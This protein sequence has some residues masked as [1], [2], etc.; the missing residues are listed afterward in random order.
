MQERAHARVKKAL[1][2]Q[3]TAGAP[4]VVLPLSPNYHCWSVQTVKFLQ[5]RSER[6][7][8]VAH[9][10]GSRQAPWVEKLDRGPGQGAARLP[11]S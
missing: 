5:K 8:D 1:R 4:V 10:A 11:G 6:K 9:R 2:S 3:H 7:L